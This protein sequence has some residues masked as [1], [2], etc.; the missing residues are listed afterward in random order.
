MVANGWNVHKAITF[1]RMRIAKVNISTIGVSLRKHLKFS[2]NAC[3]SCIEG[4]GFNEG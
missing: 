1:S 3:V 4:F 2:Y